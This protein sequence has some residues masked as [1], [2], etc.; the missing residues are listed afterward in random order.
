MPAGGQGDDSWGIIVVT[1]IYPGTVGSGNPPD[2]APDTN[3]PLWLPGQD[4]QE[5][6]GVFWGA[7]D[8]AVAV[9]AAGPLNPAYEI[10]ESTDLKFALWDQKQGTLGDPAALKL[11]SAER[12]ANPWDFGEAAG[13]HGMGL[14]YDAAASVYL[15]GQSQKGFVGQVLP[16]HAE[17]VTTFYPDMTTQGSANTFLG[18]GDLGLDINSDGSVDAQDVGA[19]ND[20]YDTDFFSAVVPGY[21][22]TADLHLTMFTKA[23]NPTNQPGYDSGY[24]WTAT[25]EDNIDGAFVPEPVTMLSAVLGVAGLAGYIRRRRVT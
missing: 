17:F 25:N 5:L 18:V 2:I 11:G 21:Q 4:G 23:N 13:P 19:A 10:A 16:G 20:Y 24:D 7:Q 12:G 6:V 9:V 14:T 15:T 3:N 22:T 8:Q 1:G